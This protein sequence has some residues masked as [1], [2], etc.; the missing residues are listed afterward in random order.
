MTAEDDEAVPV[1][2]ELLVVHRFLPAPFCG[3]VSIEAGT[4][5]FIW[6]TYQE[7]CEGLP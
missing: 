4:V 1:E 3:A 2:Q 7:T 6:N 5:W